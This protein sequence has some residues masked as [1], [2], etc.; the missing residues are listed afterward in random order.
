EFHTA[1]ADALRRSWLIDAIRVGAF[2]E[3]AAAQIDDTKRESLLARLSVVAFPNATPLASSSPSNWS[4]AQHSDSAGLPP[5]AAMPA[6]RVFSVSEID[7]QQSSPP[8]KIKPRADS[9]MQLAVGKSMV[10]KPMLQR[11]MPQ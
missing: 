9:A 5:G 7:A 1:G 3:T 8:E 6:R 4:P 11:V 10:E 2:G